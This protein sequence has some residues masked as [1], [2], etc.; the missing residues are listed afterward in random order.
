MIFF[1]ENGL[2]NNHICFLLNSYPYFNV[3]S[4]CGG[5]KL[6]TL[7]KLLKNN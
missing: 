1:S 3:Y 4:F 6:I 5:K 7:T 2:I